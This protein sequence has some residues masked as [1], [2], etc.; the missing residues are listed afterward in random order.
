MA[1]KKSNKYLMPILLAVIAVGIYVL[2]I[3]MQIVKSGAA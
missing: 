1:E 3:Y 2:S